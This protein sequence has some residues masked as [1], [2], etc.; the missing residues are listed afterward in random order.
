MTYKINSIKYM[1]IFRGVGPYASLIR[2][3]H[4][5]LNK[6]TSMHPVYSKFNI[7]KTHC[8]SNILITS[9][10]C[11]QTTKVIRTLVIIPM[12]NMIHIKI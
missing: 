5:F 6:T 12:G 7:Y 8:P 9:L 1:S 4:K 2:Q 10:K 3:L 11:Q